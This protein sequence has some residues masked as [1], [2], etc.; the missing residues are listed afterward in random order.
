MII[1]KATVNDSLA[2]VEF[3][4][5]AMEEILYEFIGEKN[6]VKATE[7]MQILTGKKGTQYSYE[8]CWLLENE[9]EIIAAAVI[10]NGADLQILKQPVI[11][12]IKT[13]FNR[14]FIPED[15]TQEGEYYID[16]IGVKQNQ[17]GKGYGSKILH[18]L[19]NK[20]VHKKGKTLGLLVDKDN[21]EAKK[22]Y[23]KLGFKVIDEIMLAG[24]HM[25]HLQLKPTV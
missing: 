18:F 23:I 4:F 9:Q 1:R 19:I 12:E 10:Y 17:Q 11:N 14:D 20:Y 22:L 7:F 13:R 25:E 15:E 5:L 6:S 8:N 3:I 24:K 2:I 21:P 16:C